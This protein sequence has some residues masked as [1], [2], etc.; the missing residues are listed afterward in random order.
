MPF[1]S[2]EVAWSTTE[3]EKRFTKELTIQLTV[4]VMSTLY[5]L[6]SFFTIGRHPIISPL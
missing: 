1:T 3:N 6:I 5:E 2:N 4:N